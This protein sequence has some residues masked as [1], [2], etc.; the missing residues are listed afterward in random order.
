MVMACAAAVA[1]HGPGLTIEQARAATAGNLCRC[2]TYPHVL[3]AA[4][5]AAK[6]AKGR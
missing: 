2:G 1:E 5:S 4:V 3:Q 6:S